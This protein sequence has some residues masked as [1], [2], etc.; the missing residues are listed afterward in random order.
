MGT[1]QQAA[2]AVEAHVF[3]LLL[4]SKIRGRI[5]TACTQH[6]NE[7]RLHR[8]NIDFRLDDARVAVIEPLK[9][10]GPYWLV[11]T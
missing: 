10:F 7:S 2:A 4:T 3:P 9:C 1:A 11:L 5:I 6:V 8:G